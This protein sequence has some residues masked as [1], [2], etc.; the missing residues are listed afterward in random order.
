MGK[1]GNVRVLSV[2]GTR[3]Q[4]VKL[5]PVDRALRERGHEHVIVDTGQHYDPLLSRAFFD[6]LAI[7]GP[8]MNLGIGSGGHAAQTACILTGLE[9]VLAG[10]SLDWVLV[11]GDTNSTL[12]GALA[13]AQHGLPLAHLEAGLRS[14]DR[15]MPEERNRVVAD[16]LSDLLLAPSVFAVR[17]LAGEGLTARAVL[18][19][20]VMVDALAEIRARVTAAPERYLPAFSRGDPYLI[21]TIH[22][23]ETTDDPAQLAAALRALA[24]LPLTV[25]LVAHPRLAD[26]ARRLSLPLSAGAVRAMDPLPYPSMIAAMMA[27]RGLVTDSGGLQKE[28]LLLGVPC[29]TLRPVT[30]WPETLRDGWNVLV[31]RPEDLPEAV[32]RARPAGKPPQPYGNGDA[33]SLVVSALAGRVGQVRSA[34][35]RRP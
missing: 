29:T 10:Q 20:D 17:N 13:A 35:G 24:A 7:P 5:A 31:P 30:E 3:P 25:R 12:G 32:L 16:H 6:D 22:R 28:A 18:V 9:P 26:R 2:V 19:G 15:R 14:F 8:M 23:A 33:A 21:A 27:S 11:Y 34:A 4:F 1:L